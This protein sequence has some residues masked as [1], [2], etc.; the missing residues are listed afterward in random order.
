MREK[1]R[2]K[3]KK[4]AM[5]VWNGNGGE[6]QQLWFASGERWREVGANLE[7]AAERA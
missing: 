6:M 1:E 7:G 5:S 3:K 2:G 4:D